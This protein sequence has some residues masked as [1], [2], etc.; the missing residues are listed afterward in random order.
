MLTVDSPYLPANLYVAVH[1]PSI[2][3]IELA[4]Q[5]T[6]LVMMGHCGTREGM[7]FANLQH[8]FGRLYLEVFTSKPERLEI[9]WDIH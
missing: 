5:R 6:G 2:R 7:A 1:A 4:P 9:E 8:P 3:R